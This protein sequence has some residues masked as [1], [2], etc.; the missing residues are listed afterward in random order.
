[1]EYRLPE[2]TDKV[3][4]DDYI[5]E[6]L[7][8][9]ENSISASTGLL[10]SEFNNWINQIH[11]NELYGNECFDKSSLY[12]CFDEDELIGLLGV[13]YDLAQ[14]KRNIYG[15]I[16]YGVRPSKRNKGYATK[17][18]KFGLNR[19]KGKGM[20]EVIVG[21]YKNNIASSSV[22]MKNGGVL[23]AENDNYKKG[24]TSQYFIINI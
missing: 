3:L 23:F 21:C 5:K 10:S 18:L 17:M 4:L 7:S 22:I 11:I 24:I 16:G 1:M 8:N 9:G 15:D 19:C 14:E 6:H 13:R 20:H 2:L 12:L